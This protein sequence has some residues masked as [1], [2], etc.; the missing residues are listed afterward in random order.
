MR[1][2]TLLYQI[3]N[4]LF[5]TINIC[6]INW[7][8]YCIYYAESEKNRNRRSKFRSQKGR[9]GN[10]KKGHKGRYNYIKEVSHD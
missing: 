8:T 6:K 3:V 4:R 10:I 7:H 5:T 9:F 2:K 1:Q